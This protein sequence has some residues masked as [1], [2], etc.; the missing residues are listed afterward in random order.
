ML[1]LMEMPMS[2]A[3]TE[4]LREQAIEADMGVSHSLRGVFGG[5][6]AGEDLSGGPKNLFI[7]V[8]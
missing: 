4:H 3:R 2:T 8:Q 1:L 6:Q 5:G 7:L